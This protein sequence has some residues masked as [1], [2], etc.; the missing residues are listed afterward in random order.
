ML[1]FK[2]LDLMRSCLVHFVL[3][4][5]QFRLIALLNLKLLIIVSYS[6]YSHFDFFD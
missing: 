3:S 2:A 5:L 6:F 1:L 4:A